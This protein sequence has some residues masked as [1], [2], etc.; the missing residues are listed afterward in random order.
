MNRLHMRI[1]NKLN[2][3]RGELARRFV[4]EYQ[5]NPGWLVRNTFAVAG[6]EAAIRYRA[7]E[8]GD[9][10]AVYQVFHCQDYRVDM[11]PQGKALAGFYAVHA[12]NKQ[13]VIIDAGAN[14]G[15]SCVY[16]STAYPESLVIAIEPEKNNCQ[17]LR[18]N[19]RGRRVEV[20]EAALGNTPGKLFLQDPG[21]S[22]WGFRVGEQGSYPVDVVTVDQLLAKLSDDQMP[23][24]LKIDIEGGEQSLFERECEWLTRF[25]LVVIELHDWMLPG[26]GSSNN[27]LRSLSKFNFDILQRGENMFCFN[28]ALLGTYYQPSGSTRH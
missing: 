11:W 17:L 3:I 16:F 18:L 9:W 7:H 21:H 4:S 1:M 28:N 20:H 26:T 22:S 27:F 23:F 2:R 10:G 12:P 25:P 8:V 5:R 15:A 19:C 14:I 6:G 24:I 13:P